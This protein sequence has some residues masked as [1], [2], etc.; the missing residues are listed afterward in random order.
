MTYSVVLREHL[1]SYLHIRVEWKSSDP[2]LLCELESTPSAHNTIYYYVS[3]LWIR[4]QNFL[5]DP[6]PELEVMDPGP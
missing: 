5:H 3:V 6:D 1:F 4:I 2:I